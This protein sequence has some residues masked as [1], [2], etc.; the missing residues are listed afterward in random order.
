M[1]KLFL[2]LKM[3]VSEH[4]Y[5]P[6]NNIYKPGLSALI[7]NNIHYITILPIIIFFEIKRGFIGELILGI[8]DIIGWFKFFLIFSLFFFLLYPLFL[9]NHVLIKNEKLINVE[10]LIKRTEIPLSD[11]KKMLLTGSLN[12]GE[13]NANLKIVSNNGTET[14]INMFLYKKNDLFNLADRLGFPNL[15][16]NFK[17]EKHLSNAEKKKNRNLRKKSFKTLIRSS[18]N[19]IMVCLIL[20]SINMAI[21]MP[22]VVLI[23]RLLN[24][25]I[26]KFAVYLTGYSIIILGFQNES[27]LGKYTNKMQ[28]WKVLLW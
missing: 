24:I 18:L 19:F 10:M 23:E 21:I 20:G 7:M 6:R 2:S 5:T 9:G 28:I 3:F 15:F 11:I 8:D 1:I 22:I 16:D 4:F 25:D 27:K 17:K 12:K 13:Y 14:N 26:L